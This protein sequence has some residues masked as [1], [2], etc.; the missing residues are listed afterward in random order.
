VEAVERLVE[1]YGISAAEYRR[2]GALKCAHNVAAFAGLEAETAWLRNRLGDGSARILDREAVAGETGSR[3]FEGGLLSPHSGTIRPLAYL[4]GMAAGLI[5]RGV[6]VHTQTPALAIERCGDRI[7]VVTPEGRVEAGQAILVTGAYSDLT[8]LTGRLRRTMVPFRSAIIAT[9]PLPPELNA[10]LLP[11]ARSYTETRRMMRWFRKVD[12]R[13]IFGGRGALG[14]VD[15]PRA[16][17]SLRRAMT[18]IFPELTE[19]PVG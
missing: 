4:L 11:Q 16:F 17:E 5:A 15:V 3:A 9:N 6:A 1:R 18:A 2:S 8:P 19:V 10:R 7:S 13:V 14:P 12:G